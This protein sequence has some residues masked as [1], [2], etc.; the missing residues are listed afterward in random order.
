MGMHCAS[1]AAKIEDSI[2]KLGGVRSASVNFASREI[3]ID[4]DSLLT[5]KV[6][7][8]NVVEKLGY[9]LTETASRESALE[10]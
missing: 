9:Q 2:K 7:I 4:F 1:C 6:E 5:P 3:H 8:L 10:A